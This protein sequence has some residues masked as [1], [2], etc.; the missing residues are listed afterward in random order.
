MH[1]EL[2]ANKIQYE[3]RVLVSISIN[4]Y[5]IISLFSFSEYAVA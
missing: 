2:N 4:Q 5:N 1:K 3:F